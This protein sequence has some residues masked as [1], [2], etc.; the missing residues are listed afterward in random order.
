MTDIITTTEFCCDMC[1]QQCDIVEKT[2]FQNGFICA[3]CSED[4]DDWLAADALEMQIATDSEVDEEDEEKFQCI[5]CDSMQSLDDS[6]F[7]NDDLICGN[8]YKKLAEDCV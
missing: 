1:E 6:E 4:L 5:G 8:C 2:A 7:I 3:Q